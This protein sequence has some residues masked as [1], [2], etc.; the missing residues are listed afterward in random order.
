MIKQQQ[1]LQAINSYI[2]REVAPLS[3]NM[4]PIQQLVFGMELGIIKRKSKNMLDNF[5][6]SP[7]A[8][9]LQ[10]IDAN[11]DIDADLLYEALN[12]SMS[13]QGSVEL[14][15]VKFTSA[16]VNKLYAIIK[17]QIGYETN[18]TLGS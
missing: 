14:M 8:K 15:G 12:E 2:D 3:N 1:L 18:N 6:N 17:E 13:K 11:G 10:L 5:I 7:S 4:L 16:D 9:L